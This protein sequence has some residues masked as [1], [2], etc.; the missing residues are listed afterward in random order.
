[1]FRSRDETDFFTMA[2]NVSLQMLPSTNALCTDLRRRSGSRSLER[3][4][5]KTRPVSELVH[6][7][8]ICRSAASRRKG[9]V[10]KT[11]S[12][13]EVSNLAQGDI[14]IFPD[15]IPVCNAEL[16]AYHML[17]WRNTQISISSTQVCGLPVFDYL[18]VALLHSSCCAGQSRQIN[19]HSLP[20]FHFEQQLL[21]TKLLSNKVVCSFLPN[22]DYAVD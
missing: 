16:T 5:G 3:L 17:I 9:L 13:T 14:N 1:M 21:W 10:M 6:A 8:L 11:K 15:V 4:R 7:S 20:K 19:N 2:T 18:W 22:L 12:S